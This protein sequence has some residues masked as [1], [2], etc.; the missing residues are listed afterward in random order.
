MCVNVQIRV[1][2]ICI[3]FRSQF[4]KEL[5]MNKDLDDFETF[6]QQQRI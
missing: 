5:I 4:F 1:N 2:N 3:I 6:M